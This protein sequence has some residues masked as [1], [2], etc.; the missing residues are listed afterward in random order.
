[1]SKKDKESN[2]AKVNDIAHEI[3]ALAQNRESIED[4]VSLIVNCLNEN[5]QLKS[6]E[7][8]QITVEGKKMSV[9][10][11]VAITN[12]LFIALRKDAC[13]RNER[14]IAQIYCD[15]QACMNFDTREYRKD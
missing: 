1:M 3:W 9:K 6:K 15:A 4:G 2:L 14:R 12:A 5:F 10:Q 13:E 8:K 11:S 7:A